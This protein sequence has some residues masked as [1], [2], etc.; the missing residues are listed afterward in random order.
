MKCFTHEV[1]SCPTPGCAPLSGCQRPGCV[2]EKAALQRQRDES[3]VDVERV[4][5]R[6]EADTQ[7]IVDAANAT[8]EAEF[9]GNVLL[10]TVFDIERAN[11]EFRGFGVCAHCGKEPIRIGEEM[12]AHIETCPKH[13]FATLK[14]N[15]TALLE[16]R[17]D[18]QAQL[19]EIHAKAR[20]AKNV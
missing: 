14:A 11:A 1:E 20:E 12:R 17:N 13:P 15:Y 18:L 3:A 19:D 9:A 4:T 10:A 8:A 5:R 16:S 6:L 7:I 2:A